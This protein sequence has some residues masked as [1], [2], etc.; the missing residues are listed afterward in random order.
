MRRWSWIENL[1][2]KELAGMELAEVYQINR[3]HYD[4]L[5]ESFFIWI[6]TMYRAFA[7]CHRKR[8]G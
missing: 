4:G 7:A 8:Q 1:T 3:R 5:A 6:A 2:A